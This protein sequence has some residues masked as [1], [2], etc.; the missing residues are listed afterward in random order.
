LSK[1]NSSKDILDEES[2][3]QQGGIGELRRWKNHQV[4]EEEQESEE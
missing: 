4:V 3:E 2:I 1:N